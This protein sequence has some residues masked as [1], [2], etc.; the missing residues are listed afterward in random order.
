[1]SK[2]SQT[3]RKD[4]NAVLDFGFDWRGASPG[5]WLEADET[6]ASSAWSADAGLTIDSS[7][8]GDTTTKVWLSGGTAGTSYTVRNRITTSKGRTD[9][10]SFIVIV[11]ER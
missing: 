2:T 6:I 5:P 8:Y 4:P 3:F 9:D 11:E 10:R 1:M 7:T